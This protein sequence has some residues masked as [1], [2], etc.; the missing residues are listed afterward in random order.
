MNEFREWVINQHDV[1]C[2]QKYDGNQPYS[3]HL[4]FV[5]AQAKKYLRS[6]FFA[7]R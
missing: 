3:N 7:L 5:E 2:N 6:F 4:K 1:V